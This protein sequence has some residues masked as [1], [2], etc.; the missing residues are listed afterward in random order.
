MGLRIEKSKIASSVI[1]VKLILDLIGETE[2]SFFNQLQTIWTPPGLD[3]GSA[4]VTTFYEFIKIHD[5]KF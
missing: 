3:P 4:G 2:S 1:P 5:W